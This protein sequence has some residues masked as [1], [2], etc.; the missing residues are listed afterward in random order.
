[1]SFGESSNQNPPLSQ[2]DRKVYVENLPA[3]PRSIAEKLCRGT[4]VDFYTRQSQK[5]ARHSAATQHSQAKDF[6]VR[7]PLAAFDSFPSIRIDSYSSIRMERLLI[8]PELYL[9]KQGG[10]TKQSKPAK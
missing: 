8:D 9:R 4:L 5:H 1:L 6:Q 3:S 7:D 10:S 2:V